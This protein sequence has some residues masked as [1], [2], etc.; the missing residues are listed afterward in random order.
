[1]ESQERDVVLEIL[2]AGDSSEWQLLPDKPAGYPIVIRNGT[3]ESHDVE[4]NVVDRIDWATVN[5][6]RLALRPGREATTQLLLAAGT[7]TNAPAGEHPLTLELHDFEGTCLGQLSASVYIVPYYRLDMS[8]LVR[9]PLLRR[10]LVEGFVL[11]CKIVN[12]GNAECA[13]QPQSDG[14]SCIVL[15]SP[16]VRIPAGGD[17]SFDIQAR[18]QSNPM[19]SYPAAVRV[20][21]RYP[22][23]EVLAEIPWDDVVASLGSLIPPLQEDEGFPEIITLKSIARHDPELVGPMM[24]ESEALQRGPVAPEPPANP[25][26]PTSPPVRSDTASSPL[27]VEITPT[28]QMKYTYGRRLNPWWPPAECFGGRWRVKALPIV[29]VVMICCAL[30]VAT[31]LEG[32]RTRIQTTAASRTNAFVIHTR[33]PARVFAGHRVV[34][35]RA[36]GEPPRLAVG[37]RKRVVLARPASASP[38]PLHRSVANEPS[39]HS[40]AVLTHPAAVAAAAKSPRELGQVQLPCNTGTQQTL[41]HPTSGSDRVSPTIRQ[42]TIVASGNNNNLFSTRNQWILTLS[43][44]TGVVLT[45]GTLN[46]VSDPT[47][48]HPYPSDFYYSSNIPTLAAGRRYQAFLSK[49][50]GACAP[51]SLGS[52]S[53]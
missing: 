23:G 52:F 21:T 48:P 27:R 19:R 18:W 50:S 6:A 33:R 28:K 2:Q 37:K 29:A 7:E 10:S 8:I 31:R 46:L 44:N 17:V 24:L 20:R 3:S 25:A 38:A 41:A 15:T 1:M 34:A 45:G 11:H 26:P 22:H 32:M 5:P 49:P 30:F 13:V 51:Q 35:R 40:A 14:D 9:G 47:G 39:L 16:T 4:I 42:L 36:H 12:R 53:T 43:D